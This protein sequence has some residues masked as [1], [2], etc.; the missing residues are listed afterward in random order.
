MISDHR[1][2]ARHFSV[3]ILSILLAACSLLPESPL[4]QVTDPFATWQA[5][6]RKLADIEE[7]SAAGRIAIRAAD[8]AWN[9]NMRWQQRI[10][11][12]R[13]RFNAPLAL[14]AAEIT[15]DPYG[16][17]LRTTNRRTFFATD[18]ESLLWD[19]LGWR[20]PVSGLRYWILGMT[21]ED[22]PVDGLEIDAAGRLEQLHQSGWKIRYLG[23]RRFKDMDLPIRLELENDRLNVRIRISRWVLAPVPESVRSTSKG[24]SE[25]SPRTNEP[26]PG[27]SGTKKVR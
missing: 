24:S 11:D 14:G 25:A 26:Q 7:W 2:Y 12:Y 10:D 18:P 13:I 9:V 23:Y 17:R 19:T 1:H 27:K 20:I 15:G 4:I 16:V 3:V 8:D 21:D 5:R 6:S 22:A